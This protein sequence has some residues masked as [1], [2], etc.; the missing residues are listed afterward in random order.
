MLWDILASFR[1]NDGHLH[2]H[3]S[4]VVELAFKI[5][6]VLLFLECGVESQA[7]ALPDELTRRPEQV[8]Q[9]ALVV[10]LRQ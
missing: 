8:P 7:A 3:S 6:P 9:A 2:Y 5:L 1:G 4:L 10:R